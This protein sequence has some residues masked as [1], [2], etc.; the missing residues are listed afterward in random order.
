MRFLNAVMLAAGVVAL[1][2]GFATAWAQPQCADLGGT[3]DQGTICRI[4]AATGTYKFDA[5]YP[6]DYP[7]QQAPTD[8]LTQTRD[9]FVN[10]SQ[11][12]GSRSLPYQL[13][14][15]SDQYRS[16][17]PPRATQSVVLKIFEDVGGPHPQ[18]WYKAF[19]YDTDARKPITFDTLFAPGTKPLDVIFPIV[20]DQLER[21]A[22][23]SGAI[24]PADGLD[25]A[26]YQN[27]AITDDELIFFFG[28]GE[29]MPATAGANV[30]HV[31][32]SAV[33]SLLA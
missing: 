1:W 29:L 18:T 17:R 23:P 25:P 16:T 14:I 28:Q 8:Y 20:R 7:D 13:E 26:H 21:Q 15:D 3:L 27:F 5:S 19:N 24:L 6:I 2:Q 31:P 10:V 30:A 22:A 33:A 12:P 32:R 9:G 4:H 11:M